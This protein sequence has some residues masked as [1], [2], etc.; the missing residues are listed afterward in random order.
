MKTRLLIVVGFGMLL[1]ACN[2]SSVKDPNLFYAPEDC[3][4]LSKHSHPEYVNSC[5]GT[6]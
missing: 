3:N 4:N 5:G 6:P 1:A 2:A